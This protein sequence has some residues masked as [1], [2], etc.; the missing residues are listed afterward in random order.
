METTEPE[1][2]LT[3]GFERSSGNVFADLGVPD[4]ER[5]LA[6]AQVMLRITDILS[7]RGVTQREAAD[8]LGISQ[9]KVSNLINGKLSQFSLD[10]LFQLLNALDRDVE[11]TI[12]P[13]SADEIAGVRVIMEPA[14][15]Q[16]D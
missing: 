10:H 3:E 14:E 7:E 12:K 11:I 16:P 5:T 15:L 2:G 9:P 6:R 1:S 13:K 4:P 8:I